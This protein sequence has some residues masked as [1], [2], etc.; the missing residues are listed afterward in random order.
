MP[1]VSWSRAPSLCC[2]TLLFVSLQVCRLLSA[3]LNRERRP[4]DR[5][6]IL[7]DHMDSKENKW[8][9][10][11]WFPWHPG[12]IALELWGAILPSISWYRG[13]KIKVMLSVVGC[14]ILSDSA[15]LARQDL[16]EGR[17]M[18]CFEGALYLYF[19]LCRRFVGHVTRKKCALRK[20]NRSRHCSSSWVAGLALCRAGRNQPLALLWA[21][22]GHAVGL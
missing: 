21:M 22:G 8:F 7:T 15:G 10:S 5:M 11:A 1:S 2:L 6:C 14:F 3:W 18:N 12:K 19:C 20:G 13:E 4:L 9:P 17:R 16:G